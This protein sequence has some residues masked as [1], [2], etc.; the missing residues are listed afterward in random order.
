[1]DAIEA[2]A[3]FAVLSE[4][5]TLPAEMGRQVDL[6]QRAARA[7]SRRWAGWPP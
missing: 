5:E 4:L 3:D 6:L 2:A 1:M 7:R